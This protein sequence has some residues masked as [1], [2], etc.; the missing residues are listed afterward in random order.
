[1]DEL[2]QSGQETKRFLEMEYNLTGCLLVD[3]AKTL[4][5]IRGLLSAEDFQN[6]TCRAIYLAALDLYSSGKPLDYALIQD[7]AV[8]L[9]YSF[10]LEISREIRLSYSTTANAEE[11]ARR[12]HAESQNR[13]AAALG[14]DM[15][16]RRVTPLEANGKLQEILKRQNYSAATPEEMANEL[17]DDLF[18][19]DSE[20][21]FL[22]TGYSSLDNIF[23]GGFIHGG[24]Y[25]FAARTNVGKTNIAINISERVAA[26][27]KRYCISHWKCPERI[28][29]SGGSEY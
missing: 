14:L 7:K 9:G 22:S 19:E 8:S 27:G 5:L 16:Y 25:V 17:A 10:D 2:L 21:P 26:R 3:T 12:M 11:F 6:D 20:P 15:A 1:M 24:L 18:N 29:I 28:L 13:Q 23:S 4:K